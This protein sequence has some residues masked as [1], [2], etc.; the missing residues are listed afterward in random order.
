MPRLMIALLC[1]TALLCTQAIAEENAAQPE[2]PPSANAQD[3][4]VLQAELARVEAERQQLAE[5]LAGGNDS[6]LELQRLRE[7]NQNLRA[8]QLD[9]E[10]GA[11]ARLE[12]QRQQ[13]FI[14]GGATVAGSLLL[15]FLLARMGGRRKRSEWLN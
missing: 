2:S 14:I 15:G 10:L 9:A 1:G 11:R 8:R 5:Q 3:V 7:E 13:W 6:N 4:G 12:E